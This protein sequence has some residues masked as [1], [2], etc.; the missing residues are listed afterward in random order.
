MRAKKSSVIF[1]ATT[2]LSIAIP[3]GSQAASPSATPKPDS[4]T[5]FRTS[6]LGN[7]ADMKKD[8]GDAQIALE[9]GGSWK[10]L[11]N[12]AEI[13]FNVGQLQALNPPAQYSKTWAKQVAELDLLSDNFLE[14]ISGGSVSKTRSILSKMSKLIKTMDAYVKKVK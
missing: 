1:I 11:G 14:S 9:K 8:I 12:A 6:A 3:I 7:L 2:L 5:Y 10:L 4:P 13:A